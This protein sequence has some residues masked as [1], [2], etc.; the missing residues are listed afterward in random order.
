MRLDRLQDGGAKFT[1]RRPGG[2]GTPH[3]R[4]EGMPGHLQQQAHCDVH[5]LLIRRHYASLQAMDNM[6]DSPCAW[7]I[8]RLSKAETDLRSA[9]YTVTA[10]WSHQKI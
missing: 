4:P 6:S 5:V 9:D 1:P 7:C 10:V 2:H 3:P 8:S